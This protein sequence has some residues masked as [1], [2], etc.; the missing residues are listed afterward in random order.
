VLL[1]QNKHRKRLRHQLQQVAFV[2][3]FVD[4]GGALVSLL[5]RSLR[6]VRKEAN[7]RYWQLRTH[8]TG[9]VYKQKPTSLG[10][11]VA[12]GQVEVWLRE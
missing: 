4:K 10:S 11:V 5:H 9:W 12:G 1:A 3:D 7:S 6:E 8:G 2:D